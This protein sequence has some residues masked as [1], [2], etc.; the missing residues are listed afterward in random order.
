VPRREE[1]AARSAARSSAVEGG[2]TGRSNPVGVR[3][4]G[5]MVTIGQRRKMCGSMKAVQLTGDQRQSRRARRC[6][7]TDARRAP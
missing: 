6:R 1:F 4:H 2:R 3:V 5:P 7:R